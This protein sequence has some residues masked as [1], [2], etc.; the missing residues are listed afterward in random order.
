M[1]L[2]D[3]KTKNNPN[4]CPPPADKLICLHGS[5]C[6]GAWKIKGYRKNYKGKQHFKTRKDGDTYWRFVDEKGDPI[7]YVEAWSFE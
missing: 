6:W 5:G 4:T 1:Q 2:L 7:S 3:L